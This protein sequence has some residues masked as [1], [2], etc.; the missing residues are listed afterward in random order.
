MAPEDCAHVL[1]VDDDLAIRNVLTDLLME[2]GYKVSVAVHGQQA[3]EICAATPVPDLIL[4][5]LQMPVMDGV[6]FS[7]LKDRDPALSRIPVCVMAAVTAATRVPRSA[8]VVLRK[9]LGSSDLLSVVK[10]FC[11]PRPKAS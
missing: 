2:Q 10:R 5:D 9:P 8:S 3:L 6:E 7:R 1:V 11:G 4:L